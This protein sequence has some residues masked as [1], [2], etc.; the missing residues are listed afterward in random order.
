MDLFF[1]ACFEGYAGD[2]LVR[3]KL[4]GYGM[5]LSLF[6]KEDLLPIFYTAMSCGL[7]GVVFV[8]GLVG[9]SVCHTFTLSLCICSSYSNLSLVLMGKNVMEVFA[10]IVE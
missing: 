9:F 3:F 7:V 1:F 6:G 10:G 8:L 2:V 5:V 4:Y